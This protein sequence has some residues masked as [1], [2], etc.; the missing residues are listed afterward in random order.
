MSIESTDIHR[1]ADH[2]AGQEL[3]NSAETTRLRGMSLAER[4][5]M[6]DAACRAAAELAAAR[7]A[8]GLPDPEPAP[9]PASTVEF[10][11]KHAQHVGK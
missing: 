8:A 7:R 2:V 5:E 1:L 4:G 9:W 3:S 11:R 6:L 10:L